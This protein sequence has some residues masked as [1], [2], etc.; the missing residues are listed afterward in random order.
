[1]DLQRNNGC[2]II[3]WACP[4]LHCCVLATVGFWLHTNTLVSSIACAQ[5][6]DRPRSL[7]AICPPLICSMAHNRSPSR[8]AHTAILLLAACLCS[9]HKCSRDQDNNPPVVP[10]LSCPPKATHN[11]ILLL[12]ATGCF[13]SSA[14]QTVESHYCSRSYPSETPPAEPAL[15]CPSKAAHTATLLLTSSRTS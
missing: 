9:C 4:C 15:S 14:V 10:A 7:F 13:C 1:M 5:V 6:C 11:A 2:A 8:A 12:T 3:L